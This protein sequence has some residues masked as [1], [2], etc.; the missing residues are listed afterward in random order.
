MDD[1]PLKIDPK[2]II[3]L[4]VPVLYPCLS[5]WE[6]NVLAM[7][8]P[9]LVMEYYSVGKRTRAWSLFELPIPDGKRNL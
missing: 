7:S 9:C 4:S 6:G 5:H 2:L 3:S 1:G 8:I